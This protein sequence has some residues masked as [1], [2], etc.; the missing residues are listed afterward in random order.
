MD[1]QQSATSGNSSE[2][3][4]LRK[5]IADG[6]GFEL[7][8]QYNEKQSAEFLQ[9]HAVTLKKK[10]LKSQIGFL[11]KGQ[12]TIA[13]LGFQLADYLI[14]NIQPC[15]KNQPAFNLETSGS[16]N[17]QIAL[18]GIGRGS[19]RTPD[20]QAVSLLALKTLKSPKN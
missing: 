11:R 19:M 15:Q 20:R 8:A 17:E 12:R 4:E 18:S 3:E 5:A 2:H 7:F 9:I 16:R 1:L 10:R 13:Y 6:H 14:T